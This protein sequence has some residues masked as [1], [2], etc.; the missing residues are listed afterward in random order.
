VPPGYMITWHRLQMAV[1]RWNIRVRFGIWTEKARAHHFLL[2]TAG[3]FFNQR[4]RKAVPS[5]K[6]LSVALSGW[7]RRY[8]ANL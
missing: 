8:L 3:S 1:L 6:R 2:T 7:R 5:P 4:H